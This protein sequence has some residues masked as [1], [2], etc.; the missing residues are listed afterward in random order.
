MIVCLL[1]RLIAESSL[2]QFWI[3]QTMGNQANF[4]LLFI[5]LSSPQTVHSGVDLG[6]NVT[7][8]MPSNL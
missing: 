6:Q 5:L 2:N 4:N 7:K 8:F 1:F 3:G